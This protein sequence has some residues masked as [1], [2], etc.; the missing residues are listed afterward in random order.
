[1]SQ[2]NVEVVRRA[3]AMFARTRDFGPFLASDAELVN[4]PRSPF[5][6]AASGANGLREWLRDIDDAF[7]EWEPR[8]DAVIEAPG[9]KVV[10]LTHFRGRG[11]GKGA[12]VEMEVD[13][14]YTVADGQIVRI[15]GY[16]TRGEALEAAGLSE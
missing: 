3:M 4:A 1:M 5:T 7:E 13:I 9:D 2:E 11:R 10:V 15:E 6:V 8:A 16:Y 14:V 12:E